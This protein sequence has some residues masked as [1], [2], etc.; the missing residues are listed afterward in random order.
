MEALSENLSKSNFYCLC[1]HENPDLD[2][3]SSLLSLLLVLNGLGFKVKG[4]LENCP[5][6]MSFLNGWE[7]Y[8]EL[9]NLQIPEHYQ[10]IALDCGSIERIWPKDIREGSSGMINIDHHFDNPL[11]GSVNICDHS[12]S[13]TAE[14]L[15]T[16]FKQ[17]GIAIDEK[18]ASNIYAG[19]LFDTGGFRYSNSRANTF[20]TVVEL[21]DL[22]LN[23]SLMADRVFTKWDEKGFCALQLA[24]A[25]VEYWE[26]N[27]I[28]Y[29]FVSFQ[30]VEKYKLSNA[31]FEG[32]ID[33]LRMNRKTKYSIFIRETEKGDFKGSVRAK[34]PHEIGEAI[35]SLGGGGHKRAAGF[36]V[37]N[38]SI[39]EIK[40]ILTVSF[41]KLL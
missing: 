16:L 10:V 18:I 39:E 2:A 30:E 24:L 33:I 9:E 3:F 36:S 28:L 21:I 17:D 15:F 27:Q 40:S 13:S 29:S 37:K 22:G 6:W 20:K 11:F 1:V 25:N 35:R 8:K 12:V 34:E 31:D 7:L 23:P 41:K 26:E 32:I 14:L 5:E 4:Y 38:K 19:I